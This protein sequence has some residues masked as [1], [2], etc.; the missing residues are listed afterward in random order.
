M[1]G[2]EQEIREIDREIKAVRRTA[3]SP[4]LEEKLPWQKK[5]REPEGGRGKLRRERFARQDG[6]I[7]RLEARPERRVEE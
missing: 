1:N 7:G 2:F 6:L 4:T 5:R 3:V